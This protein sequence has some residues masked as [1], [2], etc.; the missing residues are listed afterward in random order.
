M[1][2]P[3]IHILGIS[4]SLRAASFST[5]LLWNARELLP[6]NVSLEIADLSGIPLFNQDLE[7]EPP[8]DVRDFKARIAGADAVLFAVPEYN[9]SIPGVLKNAIDWASRPYAT[10]PFSGKP[11]AIMGAGGR[12]GT[13]RAQLHFRQIAT[14]LNLQLLQKPEL[15]I[16]LAQQKFDADG[17]LTDQDARDGLR[18][19]LNALAA[20]AR[21][22]G[23][24]P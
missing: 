11:G 24:T 22:L 6:E 14:Y 8:E 20:W 7:N 2:Q 9:Y 16:P 5:A 17:R 1:A 3:H 23:S 19:L 15:M 18:A 13:V 4:G 21:R 10:Q 12:F